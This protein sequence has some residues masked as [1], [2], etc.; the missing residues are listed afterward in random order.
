MTITS[1]E[2][3]K[4]RQGA[5]PSSDLRAVFVR[6]LIVAGVLLALVVGAAHGVTL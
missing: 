6:A 4:L 1:R 5:Y 2:I 3:V